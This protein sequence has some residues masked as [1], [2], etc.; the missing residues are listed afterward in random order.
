M[1]APPAIGNRCAPL[2]GR[3]RDGARGPGDSP[4]Q[5][6]SAAASRLL[7]PLSDEAGVFESGI[8]PLASLY[9]M[10]LFNDLAEAR[11]SEARRHG[12]IASLICVEMD[13]FAEIRGR[14]GRLVADAAMLSVA[15]LLRLSLRREDMVALCDD[16]TFLILLMHCDGVSAHAKA[17]SFR[18]AMASMDPTGVGLT[19]SVGGAAGVTGPGLR[20]DLLMT[21]ATDALA[22]ARSRG[23]DCVVFEAT[24]RTPRV[25]RVTPAH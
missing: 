21:R 17:E 24:P 23:G 13:N 19:V 4:V 11:F 10:P 8:E 1:R 18:L 15:E 2:G 7:S 5:R 12:F 16:A 20:F 22:S 9:G 6:S 25:D 14:H 3:N